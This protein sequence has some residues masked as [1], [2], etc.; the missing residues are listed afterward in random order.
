MRQKKWHTWV[1]ISNKFPTHRFSGKVERPGARLAA[2]VGRLSHLN[3][4][5]SQIMWDFE[6]IDV[7]A[8]SKRH[9][10]VF[11]LTSRSPLQLR[12]GWGAMNRRSPTGGSA[13]GM[14]AHTSTCV[15][16]IYRFLLHFHQFHCFWWGSLDIPSWDS[17]PPGYV[18]ILGWWNISLKTRLFIERT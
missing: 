1:K 8:L 9:D 12:F 6:G 4:N 11:W 7:A 5:H 15:S 3:W 18:C 16:P 2:G 17:Q 13:N 10:I 14:L